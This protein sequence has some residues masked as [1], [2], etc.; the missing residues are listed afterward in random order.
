MIMAHKQQ[1]PESSGM[2]FRVLKGEKIEPIIL[3]PAKQS[4]RNEAGIRQ[5]QINK[6]R[7]TTAGRSSLSEIMKEELWAKRK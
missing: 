7:E 5:S 2:I 1:R 3:Y 4:F 6:N